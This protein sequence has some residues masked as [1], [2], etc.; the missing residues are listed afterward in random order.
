MS[1][2]DGVWEVR[3]VSG[4]VP[5]LPGL[6]KRIQGTRG[7]TLLADGTAL[8]EMPVGSEEWLRS[9]I[10]SYRGEAV[11]LEPADLRRALARHARELAAELGVARLRVTAKAA[12]RAAGA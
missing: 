11:V 4:A 3:R 1:E 6:R 9:E 7:A 2:L 10:Y 12:G 8:K 5:P